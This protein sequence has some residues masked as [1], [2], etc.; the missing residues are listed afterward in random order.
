MFAAPP[1]N[2]RCSNG[3]SSTVRFADSFG[4]KPALLADPS[5]VT[6]IRIASAWST[7]STS[8]TTPQAMTPKHSPKYARN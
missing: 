2:R 6:S 1:V 7:G 8:G 4:R 5:G 3:T